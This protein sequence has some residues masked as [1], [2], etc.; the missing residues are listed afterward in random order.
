VPELRTDWLTG[1][2]VL[3]AEN[4]AAR[5]NE[6]GQALEST[7][8]GEPGVAGAQL[9]PGRQAA[10][11][12]FCPG[13]EHRT[14]P[15][16]YEVPDLHGHWQIRVVPNKFP[17][18]MFPSD[19][20]SNAAAQS[21]LAL[22]WPTASLD[23]MRV[24]TSAIGVHEVV[25]ESPR[26]V[27][28]MSALS[29]KELRDVFQAY[30]ARLQYWRAD[31]RLT[32]GFVFKNQGPR[33]GA[34]LAHVHSQLVALPGVP[35]AVHAE[36][37][38]AERGFVEKQCCPYCRL[39]EL[40]RSSGERIVQNSDGFIAFCPFASW[41]PYEVWLLPTG[42]ASSFE[43]SSPRLFDALAVTLHDLIVRVETV[44]PEAGYNL[45]LRTMPWQGCDTAWCHWRIELLPR[46]TSLAGLE[47]GAG[48]FINP[49][50]P[51]RA[52]GKLRS[53]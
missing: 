18:V 11:C 28:R 20:T 16:V 9:T 47:L 40:E 2:S 36:I 15:A 43:D 26:H 13:Q 38:R 34:S 46:A 31:G 1:R 10:D 27:D 32:Y 23:S 48:V 44:V 39:I 51:E 8:S 19:G 35:P 24:A 33:A 41:Q 3:V 25:I 49:V 53:A 4:R 17:A 50:A 6:F 29:V 5:P 42:H 21:S 52:A 30:A 45:L 12:P 22:S 7:W 37:E 14:P